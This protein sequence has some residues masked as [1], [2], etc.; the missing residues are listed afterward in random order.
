MINLVKKYSLQ[1]KKAF[2]KSIKEILEE[3]DYCK[4]VIRKDFIQ[5]LFMS[6]AR[7]Q[8]SNRC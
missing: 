6:V 2:N 3:H 5:N 7:F 8:S 4:N 1:R